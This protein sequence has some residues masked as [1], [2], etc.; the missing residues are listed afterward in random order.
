MTPADAPFA[1]QV[2]APIAALA[3]IVTEYRRLI[4][5]AHDL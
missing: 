4:T 3:V 2:A 1:L 5:S